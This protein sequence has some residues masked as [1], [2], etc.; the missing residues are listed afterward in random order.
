MHLTTGSYSSLVGDALLREVQES[1][2]VVHLGLLHHL[3]LD[4]KHLHPQLPAQVLLVD[5]IVDI[6]FCPGHLHSINLVDKG[7]KETKKKTSKP[8]FAQ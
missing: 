3:L 7:K 5:L 8:T 6:C 2:E 4:G 1:K